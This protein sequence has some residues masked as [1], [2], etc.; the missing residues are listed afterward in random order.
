M[1]L[2]YMSEIPA[3]QLSQ[4]KEISESL[5]TPFDATARV[6]QIMAS[7]GWLK[8]EQGA[9]GG[10]QL[11][12][13]LSRKTFFELSEMILGPQELAKCL[14]SGECGLIGRCNIVSPISVLNKNLVNFLKSLS[15]G[16]ILE[17]PTKKISKKI[18]T[19]DR[20][21]AQ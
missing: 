21:E 20:Q 12:T 6:M 8:S 9:H 17:M 7:H 15:L 1:A 10:Y 14:K 3:G 5:G 13:D 19:V 2:K 16:A 4:V 18:D 11:V